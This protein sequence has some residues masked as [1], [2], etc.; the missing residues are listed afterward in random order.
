M[1]SDISF[2][3]VHVT[4]RKKNYT[5]HVDYPAATPVYRVLMRW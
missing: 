4:I 5:V 3:F 2:T 1:V